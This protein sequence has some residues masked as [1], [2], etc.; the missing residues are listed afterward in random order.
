MVSAALDTSNTSSPAGS[1]FAA[2]YAA[3]ANKQ[4]GLNP[5]NTILQYGSLVSPEMV[6]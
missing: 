2:Y 5:T 4:N 1:R 3:V 6:Q